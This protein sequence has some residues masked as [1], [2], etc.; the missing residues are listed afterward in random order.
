[1]HQT[2][3]YQGYTTRIDDFLRIV[4]RFR[5]TPQMFLSRLIK[6]T[7]ETTIHKKSSNIVVPLAIFETNF[8]SLFKY[9]L[10][11]ITTEKT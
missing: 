1:M 4:C 5:Q 10:E 9:Y 7:I 2:S 11:T 6:I 3:D 8:F